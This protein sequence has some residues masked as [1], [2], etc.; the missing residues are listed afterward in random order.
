MDTV[1]T[2]QKW[3]CGG[4]AGLC[5]AWGGGDSL[6]WW[7]GVAAPQGRWCLR[8]DVEEAWGWGSCRGH[9]PRPRSPAVSAKPNPNTPDCDGCPTGQEGTGV[10]P[11]ASVHVP[12]PPAATQV[13]SAPASSTLRN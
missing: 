11:L 8:A 1:T 13:S 3:S 12:F 2:A 6:L 7:G 9:H 10:V 5:P 4:W